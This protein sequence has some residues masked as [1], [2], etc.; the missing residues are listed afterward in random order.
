MLCLVLSVEAFDLERM[1]LKNIV[2]AIS[3]LCIVY[4]CRVWDDRSLTSV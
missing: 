3:R 1:F 2:G 4:R